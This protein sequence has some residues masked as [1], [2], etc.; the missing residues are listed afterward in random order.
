MIFAA[1][2][3]SLSYIQSDFTLT[4]NCTST[5]LPPT[6]VTWSKDGVEMSSGDKHTF[7]Q[8]VICVDNTVYENIMV[9]TGGLEH[10]IQGFYQCSVQCHDDVGEVVKSAI[11][12]ANIT[13]K[14]T[15]IIV[16]KVSQ[17]I[18][19]FTSFL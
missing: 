7:S 16:P 19:G 2:L 4:L 8:R 17:N 5:G 3:V 9:V 11:A 12:F 15:S 14:S 1:L 10:D 13:S 18:N 6:T